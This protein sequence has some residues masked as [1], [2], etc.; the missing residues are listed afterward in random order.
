MH[1]NI[2]RDVFFFILQVIPRAVLYFTGEAFE[3]D[4][5]DFDDCEDE[6]DDEDTEE[7]DGGDH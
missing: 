4:D 2:L 3:D 6:E 5:D 7:D 1:F